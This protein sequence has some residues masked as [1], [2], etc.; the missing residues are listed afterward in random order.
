MHDPMPEWLISI[1][2]GIGTLP[3]SPLTRKPP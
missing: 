1:H 3:V 2:S